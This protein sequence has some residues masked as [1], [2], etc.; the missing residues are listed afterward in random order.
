[1]PEHAPSRLERRKARTRAALIRAA[2]ALIAG[3]KT[4]VPILEITQAADVGMG[5]FYNH[6]E[7][8]EQLYQAAVEDALD[9][10]GALLDGLT[11]GLDDPAQ[12]FAQSFRLTGRL[13]RRHPE[14]SKVLLH[15]GLELTTSESGLA[16][17]AR[18][19]I[20]AAVRAG[21]FTVTDT[22][23]AMVTV[24]GTALGLGHLLH[25][26]PERDDAAT[27]DQVT[28]D[29]LRMLGL[30]AA[31]AHEIC[32]RPLPDLDAAATGPDTAA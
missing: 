17:R 13:H 1:M 12:V 5:S 4:T 30:T 11:I 21:R 3:G 22:E 31:E 15:D 2:Q 6:F 9:V 27:T 29:L 23:L 14:L 19:D 7:T 25:R 32:G 24:A 10:H 26:Q 20:E 18:R 8:K 28:E 16:P